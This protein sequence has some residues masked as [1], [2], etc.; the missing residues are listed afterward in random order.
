[1]KFLLDQLI[2]T[3]IIDEKVV[4]KF[5]LNQVFDELVKHSSFLVAQEL[6][7]KI[8]DTNYYFSYRVLDIIVIVII[9]ELCYCSCIDIL[10]N[11]TLL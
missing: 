11:T 6:R 9:I 3:P 7:N 4:H 10:I 8:K 1:M 5:P 2:S